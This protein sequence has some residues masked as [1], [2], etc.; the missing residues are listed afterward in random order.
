MQAH[1]HTHQIRNKDCA[2]LIADP[3]KVGQRYA[4]LR[5]T[6]GWGG[7]GIPDIGSAFTGV[8]QS[9]GSGSLYNSPFSAKQF[10]WCLAAIDHPLITRLIAGTSPG[11]IVDQLVGNQAFRDISVLD[12]ACGCRPALARSMRTFGA[13]VITTDVMD[14]NCL[15]RE[16]KLPCRGADNENVLHVT[17]DIAD[18]RVVDVILAKMPGS[19]S[20]V[21]HAHLL[22]DGGV[23]P[24][25]F[26]LLKDG[27]FYLP[28][29]RPSTGVVPLMRSGDTLIAL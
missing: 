7:G 6:S 8:D 9:L 25:P 2:R 3:L 4:Q 5:Q 10:L 15:L 14:Q 28:V 12:I 13:T 23:M 11:Q 22:S 21:T 26:K 27:G 24:S 29:E 18:S 19:F 1:E 20:I 17:G 16:T